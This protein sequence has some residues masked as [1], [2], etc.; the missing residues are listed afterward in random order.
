[1]PMHDLARVGFELGFPS[2]G[3]NSARLRRDRPTDFDAFC[4]PRRRLASMNAASYLCSC[5]RSAVVPV[6]APADLVRNRQGHQA[7]W[8]DRL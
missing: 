6:T 3:D 4:L 7:E 2:S 8:A 1:M 5:T